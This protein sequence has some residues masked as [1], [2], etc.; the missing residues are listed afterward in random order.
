MGMGPA[1]QQSGMGGKGAGMPTQTNQPPM[2]NQAQA[3]M[4]G[5]GAGQQQGPNPQ[6]FFD[7]TGTPPE[8]AQQMQGQQSG[9]QP[10]GAGVPTQ[11]N[12][13]PLFNTN[14]YSGPFEQQYGMPAKG[15]G[16]Q[17]GPDP[18]AFYDAV[19]FQPPQRPGMGGKGGNIPGQ[20]NRN[21]VPWNGMGSGPG[22]MGAGVSFMRDYLGFN[23]NAPYINDRFD[24][25]RFSRNLDKRLEMLNARDRFRGK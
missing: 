23:R 9:M 4:G 22:G 14:P 3:G 20:P 10:K 17:Q 1:N 15:A 5:K 16:A 12:Q 11:T 2:Q 13:P 8:L 19:G 18:Q 6:A 21:G 7:R 25:N 24:G